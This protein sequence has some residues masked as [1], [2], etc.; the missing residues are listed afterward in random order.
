MT[1]KREP[2]IDLVKG[3]AI[4]AVLVDHTFFEPRIGRPLCVAW[5]Y[6][7]VALFVLIGG[8]N[9][10][11]TQARRVGDS[12]L[13]SVPWRGIRCLLGA[14]LVA[15]LVFH[16]VGTQSFALSDYLRECVSFNAVGPFYFVAFYVQLLAISPILYRSLCRCQWLALIAIALA[17]HWMTRHTLV[18]EQAYGAGKCLFG[19]YFLLAYALGMAFSLWPQPSR[20]MSCWV[21]LAGLAFSLVLG[22]APARNLIC[23]LNRTFGF[24]LYNL[25]PSGGLWL[26]V[27]LSVFF[28]VRALPPSPRCLDSLAMKAL[29][30]VGRESMM[31]FLYHVLVLMTLDRVIPWA[32]P[33]VGA[34]DFLLAA[35]VPVIGVNAFRRG[36]RWWNDSRS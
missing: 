5:S 11:R 22:C 4:L 13:S 16:V 23:S 17:A 29:L 15:V 32:H 12:L 8:Y 18:F 27:A 20:R 31:I 3:I 36:V 25:N 6:F 10:G 26:L 28:L 7:S 19:G 24:A 21:G 9:A 1:T 33:L 34:V 35:A 2:W 14:Y 30:A